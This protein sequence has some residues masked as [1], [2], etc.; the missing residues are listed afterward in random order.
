MIGVFDSGVGGLVSYKELRRL[1]PSE[2]ILYLA[3]RKNA[4]YGIKKEEELK[5]LVSA[6]IKRLRLLGADQILV[7]CCTACT[8]C[9]LLGEDESR[10]VFTLIAPTAEYI[11]RL[12]EQGQK[13]ERILIIATERTVNSEVFSAEIRKTT[14]RADIIPLSAQELVYHVESG[15]RDG[16]LSKNSEEYLNR[17]CERINSYEPDL[18]VLGCTHFSHL[19]REIGHRLP[20]AR[21]LS[22]A[23]IGALALSEKIKTIMK[24][25]GSGK[26]LYTE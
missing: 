22:P 3:D 7:A 26:S 13:N 2:D 4:P 5:K 10:S 8:V 1:L 6:D 12:K 18:L 17:L 25:Q 24:N 19:E 23:K 20:S 14:P 15:A 21:I 9:P 16:K 11:A